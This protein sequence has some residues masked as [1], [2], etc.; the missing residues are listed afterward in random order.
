MRMTTR[1]KEIL[2][3][4]E[5]DNLEWITGEIGAPP[6]DVS[7]VSYLLKGTS[8]FDKSYQLESTRRTLE[9]MVK[10][11]LLEKV[12]SYERRQD[13]TQSGDG[14]GV[15]CNCSRYGLPGQCNVMRDDGDN[16]RPHI[17]GES[18]RID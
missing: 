18:V 11:G 2:S 6:F 9:A 16:R 12:I 17:E 3:Y 14:K 1:K 10:D 13:T 15:W 7:G 5:P 4:F 8:G